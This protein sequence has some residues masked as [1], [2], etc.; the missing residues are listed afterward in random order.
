MNISFYS[1]VVFANP[2][3]HPSL[4][5][6]TYRY[7]AIIKALARSGSAARAESVLNK[8]MTLHES[9]CGDLS[10]DNIT[11]STCID[12]YAKSKAPDAFENAQRL[13]KDLQELDSKGV[14]NMQPN[15]VTYN[16]L[17]NALAYSNHPDKAEVAQNLLHEMTSKD[18][19]PDCLTYNAILRACAC[20]EGDANTLRRAL[21][22]AMETFEALHKSNATKPSYH[23]YSMFFSVCRKASKDEEYERL[24]EMGFKLCTNAGLLHDKTLSYL[25][26]NTP[27]QF[28][29]SLVRP[30]KG[31][32]TIKDLPPQWSRNT[33]QSNTHNSTRKLALN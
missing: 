20:A 28:F 13:F 6:T 1:T 32:V 31:Y 24:V 14:A 27:K 26:R 29:Q 10:P 3:V 21:R 2:E 4:Y 23:S 11:Y 12:A 15:K 33:R 18:I 5:C 17:I 8:M 19:V 7:N 22:V 25:A 30:K 16:A 9:G